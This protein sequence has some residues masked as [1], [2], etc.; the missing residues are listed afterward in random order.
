MDES[1]KPSVK[2]AA[3]ASMA[4]VLLTLLSS[5]KETKSD[6]VE[7]VQFF[8]LLVLAGYAIAEWVKYLRKY[9]D[10][11]IEQKL[12]ERDKEGKD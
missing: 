12:S 3:V 2:S 9:V 4:V 5:T 8:C 7:I 11:A 6:I 1:K 10:F